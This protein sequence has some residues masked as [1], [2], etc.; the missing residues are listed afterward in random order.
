M[1]LI[2][3]NYDSFTWNL[4]NYCRGLGMPTHVVENDRIEKSAV[5]EL[6][7]SHLLISP[8]PGRP[9]DAGISN[10]LIAAF[11][12]IIPVL[13]VCLGH[14][15]IADVFGGN[16][17]KARRPVHGKTSPIY[18][19]QS[20]LFAGLPQAF[21]T[22]RYHSL[23]VE[24]AS[25]PDCLATSAWTIS[26]DKAEVADST[27]SNMHVDE[28]MGLEHKHMNLFGVQFHPEAI[29][30][31]YGIDLLKNFLDCKSGIKTEQ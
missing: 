29:L 14:Q 2:I 22:T 23:V 9:E 6:K 5:W 27:L 25:L 28:I 3:D 30:S 18:H 13:G 24:E 7:P 15:C 1:L 10:E 20:S 26:G 11:S 19:H 17:V 21:S 16:I 12:G 4:V 8:G 31:E